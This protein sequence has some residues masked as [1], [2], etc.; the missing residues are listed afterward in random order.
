MDPRRQDRSFWFW[1]F[2]VK[3]RVFHFDKAR[4]LG[5]ESQEYTPHLV[6]HSRVDAARQGKEEEEKEE[7]GEEEADVDD[8][9][10]LGL[11]RDLEA[12]ERAELRGSGRRARGSGDPAGPWW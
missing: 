2:F 9:P 1:F 7:Q 4:S 8:A 10:P 6:S 3:H 12:D 5:D 11:S